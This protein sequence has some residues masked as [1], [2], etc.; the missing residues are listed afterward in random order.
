MKVVLSS[1]SNVTLST[2]RP[3]K[4]VIGGGLAPK[5]TLAQQKPVKAA[6]GGTI[7]PQITRALQ[8]GS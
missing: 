3:V 2:Q 7:S 1:F 6:V 5:L 8:N 4:A